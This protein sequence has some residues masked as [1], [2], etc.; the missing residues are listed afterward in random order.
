MVIYCIDC[1]HVTFSSLRRLSALASH[2]SLLCSLRSQ[3]I[4][5]IVAAETKAKSVISYVLG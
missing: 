4:V 5:E 3:D 1:K 2:R